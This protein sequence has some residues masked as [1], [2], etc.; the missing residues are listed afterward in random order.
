MKELRNKILE[1]KLWFHDEVSGFCEKA[2][3]K[4]DEQKTKHDKNAKIV[5]FKRYQKLRKK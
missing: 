3:N 5:Y 1:A 4:L 2:R